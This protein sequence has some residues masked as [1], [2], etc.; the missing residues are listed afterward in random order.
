MDHRTA[1][2]SFSV[3]AS[4]RLGALVL[5]LGAIA[6]VP[7]PPPPASRPASGLRPVPREQDTAEA[8]RVLSSRFAPDYADLTPAGRRRLAQLLIREAGKTPGDAGL[9]AA[10]TEARDM[11]LAAGE[12]ELALSVVQELTRQFDVDRDSARFALLQSAARMPLS[13]TQSLVVARAAA[14][15]TEA[16]LYRDDIDGAHRAALV[17]TDAA[18]RTGD[19]AVQSEMALLADFTSELLKLLP[20]YTDA[21]AKLTAAPD[22]ADANTTCAEFLLLARQDWGKA[23]VM[24][25]KGA[26]AKMRLAATAELSNAHGAERISAADA[27]LQWAADHKGPAHNLGLRHA[28]DLYESAAASLD[29]GPDLERCLVK[30]AEVVSATPAAQLVDAR[31]LRTQLGEPRWQWVQELRLSGLA[32]REDAGGNNYSQAVLDWRPAVD[33]NGDLPD[34]PPA[35]ESE[36]LSGKAADARMTYRLRLLCLDEQARP[37]VLE[38]EGKFPLRDPDKQVRLAGPPNKDLRRLN[39]GKTTPAGVHL[40]ISLDG[41]RVAERVWKLPVKR[42]WWLDETAIVK[43]GK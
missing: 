25:S 32:P 19:S 33:R 4:C 7:P 39:S 27:W 15:M 43:K 3:S 28:R 29:Q 24:L 14:E 26:N 40:L 21:Q 37:T 31:T 11:A 20:R 2:P 13:A 9:Y 42:A 16:R 1:Q 18:R 6:A 35:S 12:V 8:K 10:L 38:R 17:A 5:A 22:D 34:P 36:V 30:V 41:I 23:L